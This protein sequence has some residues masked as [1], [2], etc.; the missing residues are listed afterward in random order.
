MDRGN[1]SGGSPTNGGGN[2]GQQIGSLHKQFVRNQ[3]AMKQAKGMIYAQQQPTTQAA[4]SHHH[5]VSRGSSNDSP[6]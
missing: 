3:K 6:N 1:S 5:N 4:Q 2:T